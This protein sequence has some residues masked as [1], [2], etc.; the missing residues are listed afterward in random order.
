M[1]L[2]FDFLAASHSLI[3]NGFCAMNSTIK[4]FIGSIDIIGITSMEGTHSRV[5][6]YETLIHNYSAV[7]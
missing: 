5:I 7:N 1:K 4:I 2:C 3:Y 6:G